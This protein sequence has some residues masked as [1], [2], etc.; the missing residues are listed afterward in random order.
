VKKVGQWQKPW[1]DEHDRALCEHYGK[2]LGLEP[3]WEVSRVELS[4]Q[5]MKLELGVEWV[6]CRGD[7]CR[8]WQK[9]YSP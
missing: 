4:T 1:M 2:M 3:G 7:L 6:K 9:V 8:V 5:M